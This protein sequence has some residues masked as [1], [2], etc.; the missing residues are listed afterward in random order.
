MSLKFKTFNPHIAS[1]FG[2]NDTLNVIISNSPHM[3]TAGDNGGQKGALST[4]TRTDSDHVAIY[5]PKRCII[6][7]LWIPVRIIPVEDMNI[8]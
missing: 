2:V 7:V 1:I 4:H 5:E 6:R 8:Y 3:Y